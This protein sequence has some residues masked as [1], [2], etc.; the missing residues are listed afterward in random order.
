MKDVSSSSSI[1]ELPT[2]TMVLQATGRHWFWASYT[3]LMEDDALRIHSMHDKGV[4]ALQLSTEEVEERLLEI[5]KE[6]QAMAEAL[7]EDE[8][9]DEGDSDIDEDEGED[10]ADSDIDEDDESEEDELE[11]DIDEVRWF[12]KQSLHYCRAL[13]AHPP[14]R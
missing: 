8:A 11:I 7:A 4:E 13:L 10:E 2:A 9:D 3:L 5:T 1:P 14:S 12:T 6:L